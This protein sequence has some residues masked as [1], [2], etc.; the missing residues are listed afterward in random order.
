[1]RQKHIELLLLRFSNKIPEKINNWD[2]VDKTER[3]TSPSWSAVDKNKH[4]ICP[5]KKQKVREKT[6]FSKTIT[7][8]KQKSTQYHPRSKVGGLG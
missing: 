4:Q 3:K 6:R 7:G 1:M 8:T 5:E 2:T